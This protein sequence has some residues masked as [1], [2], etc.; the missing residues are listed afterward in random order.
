M[1]KDIDKYRY[2]D[3]MREAQQK[4]MFKEFKDIDKCRYPDA[5]REAQQKGLVGGYPDGTFRPQNPVTREE[6]A[7]MLLRMEK[8][9]DFMRKVPEITEEFMPSIV[10]IWGPEGVG[11]G[12]YYKEN[13]ILTNWHVVKNAQTVKADTKGKLGV[14]GKVLKVDS[15]ID[16]AEIEVGFLGKPLDFAE[17]FKQGEPCL[18]LGNPLGEY[19]GVSAGIVVRW[20]GEYMQTDAQI[21][22]GNSGGCVVNEWGEVIGIPKHKIVGSGIDN[23]NYSILNNE[24]ERF[25]KNGSV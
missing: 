1:F 22:P 21:N 15:M 16:L 24:T 4:E 8:M 2:P 12:F 11:S 18:V 17:G 20:G 5:M 10:K 14:I 3:A 13:R 9:K 19:W 25:L 23:V 6:V 7:L